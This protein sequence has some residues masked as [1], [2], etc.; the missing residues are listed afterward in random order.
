MFAILTELL[1]S[2]SPER[3]LVCQSCKDSLEEFFDLFQGEV[4]LYAQIS[5]VG[6]FSLLSDQFWGSNFGSPYYESGMTK[7]R[8]LGNNLLFLNTL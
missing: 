8:F 4:S 7:K 2:I 3:G 5:D 1:I 6:E